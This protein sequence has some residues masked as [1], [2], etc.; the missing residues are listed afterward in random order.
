MEINDIH[1]LSAANATR[2]TA[3][4]DDN[5]E[6]A[7]VAAHFTRHFD[8]VLLP[9]LDKTRTIAVAVSG[10][11]DSMAT[12]LAVKIWVA[13][14]HKDLHIICLVIDH[15]LR[16]ESQQE[17]TFVMKELAQH[18][19]QSVLLTWQHNNHHTTSSN[20]QNQAR[21]ARYSLLLKYCKNH[22]INAL[23]LGHNY[24]D[25]AETVLMR[26][27]RG[28]GIGGICGMTHTHHIDNIN[29]LRPILQISR[30]EIEIFM[31]Y[32][33][34]HIQSVQYIDDPSNSSDKYERTKIRHLIQHIENS[35]LTCGSQI[36]A[37][38]NLLSSNAKRSEDFIN[39]IVSSTKQKIT[40]WSRFGYYLIDR[41]E[42]QT[43]HMEILLRLLRDN[44]S[45]VGNKTKL[46]LR[47]RS[48]IPLATK[49]HSTNGTFHKQTLH[50]C[51]IYNKRI[52]NRDYIIIARECV[53]IN[54]QTI[55]IADNKND[56]D[57]QIMWDGRITINLSSLSQQYHGYH[58]GHASQGQIIH[59][60]Y[61]LYDEEAY[62]NH[63]MIYIKSIDHVIK[64]ALP[65]IIKPH[66]L[67]QD[68]IL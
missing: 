51:I 56:K 68:P 46:N 1:I 17:A 54:T 23:C 9:A 25:N 19:L 37:R 62:I 12:A 45:K 61:D 13:E 36:K 21:E 38:L 39:Q 48:L 29:I 30:A 43:L 42:L 3:L 31:K 20:I 59:N 64:V 33:N 4:D 8:S 15:R 27:I 53:Q 66:N 50:G 11:I 35:N 2:S 28:S 5:N 24:D 6:I 40:F 41:E 10:G 44:L 34:D 55:I 47:L 60:L 14:N 18:D 65:Y 57:N 63:N 58:I 7:N 16:P 52:N 49:I 32:Y 67:S 26:I 22:G